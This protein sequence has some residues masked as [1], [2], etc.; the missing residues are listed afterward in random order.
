MYHL[1]K[2]ASVY[3]GKI[4]DP[5][6]LVTLNVIKIAELAIP[7]TRRVSQLLENDLNKS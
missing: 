6:G 3:D 4:G 5:L 1:E 7:P 2:Y